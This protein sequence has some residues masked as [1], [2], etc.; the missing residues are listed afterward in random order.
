MK[1]MLSLLYFELFKLN[2]AEQ[3]LRINDADASEVDCARNDQRITDCM[4]F[5]KVL[6]VLIDNCISGL[7]K[8]IYQ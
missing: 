4:E 1:N 8:T 6:D 7:H 3:G 2:N 5:R